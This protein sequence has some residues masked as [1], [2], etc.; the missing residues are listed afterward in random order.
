MDAAQRHAQAVRALGPCSLLQGLVFVRPS[1][2]NPGLNASSVAVPDT[3]VPP[4]APYPL[5]TPPHPTPLE[6]APMAV[7]RAGEGG[8]GPAPEMSLSRDKLKMYSLPMVR[9]KKLVELRASEGFQVVDL[10]IG[11]KARAMSAVGG[12]RRRGMGP[13]ADVT[14]WARWTRYVH[15]ALALEY[16]LEYE[17]LVDAEHLG[18]LGSVNVTID[19]VGAADWIRVIKDSQSRRS[20]AGPIRQCLA[21]FLRAVQEID[22]ILFRVVSM[23]KPRQPQ[24]Q[25]RPRSEPGTAGDGDDDSTSDASAG[26]PGV[27]PASRGG[28]EGLRNRDLLLLARTP[29]HDWR[30]LL[31]IRYF[32]VVLVA[33]V[34]PTSS[35]DDARGEGRGAS[36][37]GALG[38]PTSD[39]DTQASRAKKELY[40]LLD[41]WATRSIDKDLFWKLMSSRK[42]RATL[43]E[44]GSTASS[45]SRPP[46]QGFIFCLLRVTWASSYVAGFSMGFFGVDP[47]VM[48]KE[49]VALQTAINE[50]ARRT[51]PSLIEG[52]GWVKDRMLI[53][54]KPMGFQLLLPN[55]EAP[56]PGLD[57]RDTAVLATGSQLQRFNIRG[58]GRLLRAYLH[59]R[60]WVWEFGGHLH[61]SPVVDV[62]ARSKLARGFVLVHA[63]SLQTV[64]VRHVCRVLEVPG[65]RLPLTVLLQYRITLEP[66][67]EV[68]TE[69]WM[70]PQYGFSHAGVAP[71]SG[72]H[73]FQELADE[74][75]RADRRLLSTFNTFYFIRRV[76]SRRRR[77]RSDQAP[78]PGPLGLNLGEL[79]VGANRLEVPLRTFCEEPKPSLE[80]QSSGEGPA[81]GDLEPA[82]SQD[83]VNTTL[84]RLLERTL[85][86]LL[87]RD[88]PLKGAADVPHG[89][90]TVV[91]SLPL[92]AQAPTRCYAYRLADD[93]L[94]LWFLVKEGGAGE[95][96]GS[97]TAPRLGLAI[98]V[99][100]SGQ[101]LNRFVEEGEHKDTE[102]LRMAAEDSPYRS[103]AL[104]S[105]VQYL[106]YMHRR[107]FTQVAYMALRHRIPVAAEDLRDAL[108]Y[109][110]EIGIDV[111]VTQLRKI[112]VRAFGPPRQ[113]TGPLQSPGVASPEAEQGGGRGHGL[114][115]SPSRPA[116]QMCS[117]EFF[118]IL[119]QFLHPV[120]GTEYYFF[121]GTEFDLLEGEGLNEEAFEDGEEEM[122]ASLTEGPATADSANTDDGLALHP[123]TPPK[124]Y[125]RRPS[126]TALQASAE[127]PARGAT[128]VNLGSNDGKVT[129]IEPF[130]ET[131]GGDTLGEAA[132]QA[133]PVF[134]PEK[135][136][137][138]GPLGK[139]ALVDVSSLPPSCFVRF[140]CVHIVPDEDAPEQP[141][142]EVF[143]LPGDLDPSEAVKWTMPSRNGGDARDNG[144]QTTL[145]SIICATHC[146][147]NEAKHAYDAATV[148]RGA[149]K[150]KSPGVLTPS[151]VKDLMVPAHKRFIRLVRRQVEAWAAGEIL[152]A[153]LTFSPLPEPTIPLVLQSIRSLLPESR[154]KFRVGL[155]FVVLDPATDSSGKSPNASPPHMGGDGGGARGA[156]GQRSKDAQQ[157]AA[158][159]LFQEHLLSGRFLSVR[160]S[161]TTYF[162]VEPRPAGADGAPLSPR[163]RGQSPID[164][165]DCSVPYWAVLRIQ[166]KRMTGLLDAPEL[167]PLVGT[168]EAPDA[169]TD[170]GGFGDSYEVRVALHHPLG[171]VWYENRQELVEKL[172]QGIL[173]TC[174]HVNQ[175]LLLSHLHDTRVA[176]PLLIPPTDS[177]LK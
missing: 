45:S 87:G 160:R 145:I 164:T 1:R 105:L 107:N 146:R 119:S 135:E 122:E 71:P 111:D 32:E 159:R 173:E 143:H 138:D 174:T 113:P 82:K 16:T 98:F 19:V 64:L 108:S 56:L 133:F 67:H 59:W 106:E 47:P 147:V 139:E 58:H 13:I 7:P 40:A 30:K 83:S 35:G 154:S 150:D 44:D 18:A 120:P 37:H 161:D 29:V 88:I 162:L 26:R 20:E 31:R 25:T 136:A 103:D 101:L 94:A 102:P 62:L 121:V 140:E 168:G 90:A 96:S 39:E 74:H 128:E 60:R 36:E 100:N 49:V 144:R 175:L 137:R 156:S 104:Q 33:G 54:E 27:E 163:E 70:E 91:Q 86:S 81:M 28:E 11:G 117:D 14:V 53:M 41:N 114:L 172:R 148:G 149:S 109:C 99:V 76:S 46:I 80:A 65:R 115:E 12:G 48:Y 55:D 63:G 118:R 24:P 2:V 166:R 57:D 132:K 4:P 77:R 69:L 97:E 123:S 3:L 155:V 51:A 124:L 134:K 38:R 6:P 126:E 177:D 157:E 73:L 23:S 17:P 112:C 85:E 176:S 125:L 152:R 21:K 43:E 5:K 92:G 42:E 22:I 158:L 72:H 79:L 151:E 93:T 127:K 8:R 167:D 68:I 153:L 50:L 116:S 78:S 169:S 131:P 15:A 52:Q 84:E 165:R 141:C 34:A 142:R 10:R 66:P 170:L 130:A 9:L 89:E 75:S 95:A 110:S 129:F 171:T 61:L